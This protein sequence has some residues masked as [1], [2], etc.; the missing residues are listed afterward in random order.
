MDSSGNQPDL[1]IKLKTP[2]IIENHDYI[3]V[4]FGNNRNL[5]VSFS[6]EKA[7]GAIPKDVFILWSE[8]HL[9]K[10]E[11]LA[12]IGFLPGEKVTAKRVVEAFVLFIDEVWPTWNVA[13]AI[14]S[15]GST[16]SYDFGKRRG[17][18]A[19]GTVDKVR[20]TTVTVNFMGH[21][22]VRMAAD[23]FQGD[24]C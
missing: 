10:P 15:V 7:S 4:S 3:R 22:L 5:T 14:P 16:V 18:I 21:G 8:C 17:G 1:E 19:T 6:G 11:A 12:K 20:G 24:K 23:L 9:N 13:P 2:T